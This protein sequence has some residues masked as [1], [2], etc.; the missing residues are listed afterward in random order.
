MVEK[1]ENDWRKN[2]E[3]RWRNERKNEVWK[4]WEMKVKNIE[5]DLK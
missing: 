2:E 3:E 1:R 4:D 5:I